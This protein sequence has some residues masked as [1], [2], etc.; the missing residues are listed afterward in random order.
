M[1]EARI[2]RTIRSRLQL[3]VCASEAKQFGSSEIQHFVDI[4]CSEGA[5]DGDAVNTTRKR[6]PKG[7]YGKIPFL[8]PGKTAINH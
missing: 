5:M 1:R 6:T 7:N 4:N 2:A 3:T 8:S